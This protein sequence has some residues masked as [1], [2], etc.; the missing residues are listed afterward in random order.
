MDEEYVEESTEE[1]EGADD[2]AEAEESETQG[3]EVEYQLDEYGEQLLDDDGNP[4]PVE[5]VE[6]DEEETEKGKTD[7]KKNAADRIQQLANEKRELADRLSKLEAQFNQQQSEKPDY[8]E[9]DMDAVNAWFE[10][11]SDQ[12]ENLKLEGNHLAAKKIELAQANLIAQLEENEAKKQAH[13]E[14]TGK[15]KAT[16]SAET[17]KL[18]KL[19]QAVIFYREHMKIEPA[20]WDKM[21]NWFA[22]K[23]QSDVLLR[24]EYQEM[25]DTQAPTAVVKWA[26]DYT[27][28]N[29]G[30]KEKAAIDTKNKNK[31][32]AS[33]AAPKTGS[34]KISTVDL[35]KALEKAKEAG[36]PEAWVEYQA[37]KRAAQ[38]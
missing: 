24:R 18:D 8:V 13:I 38:R 30:I 1:T 33:G 25:V 17:A 32:T 5:Q 27:L 37:A 26:H 23:L 36:T 21:G 31:Q 10:K 2:S 14:R 19:D 15:A 29:M 7:H 3:G 35:S 28:K 9:P 16:T 11:T 22:G 34:G 12:I 20:V 6:G 4:I